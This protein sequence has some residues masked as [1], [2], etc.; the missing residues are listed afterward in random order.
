MKFRWFLICALVFGQTVLATASG[1]RRWTRVSS[2]NFTVVGDASESEIRGAAV[3]F[4]LFRQTLQELFSDR[5]LSNVPTTVFVFKSGAELNS[6]AANAAD[7]QTDNSAIGF[8]RAGEAANYIALTVEGDSQTEFQSVFH[9]YA[10]LLL[11]KSFG[12]AALPPWTSEGLAEY[13]ETLTGDE[14][15]IRLGA[16]AEEN[17]RFL[18]EQNFVPLERLLALDYYTLRTQGNHGKSIFYAESWALIHYLQEANRGAR[19]G[20]L[21]TFLNLL[22]T[23][24]EAKAAFAEAFQTDLPTLEKELREYARQ[25]SFPNRNV[26]LK[27]N[28]DFAAAMPSA[29]LTESESLTYQSEL[30]ISLDRLDEAANLLRRAV[31]LDARSTGAL[32]ALGETLARQNKFDEA[33]AAF[34][35]AVSLD[36]R[37]YLSLFR[38]A[39]A[40]RRETL[41]DEKF[42]RPISDEKTAQITDLL[43]RSI[44]LNPN[45]AAS[46]RLM[47]LVNL[48]NN[49][50]LKDA[51]TLLGKARTLEPG[52]EQ[53]LLDLGRVYFRLEKFDEARALARQVFA[54]AAETA[55]RA[56]AQILLGNIA[57]LEEQL[58]QIR[59]RN[60]RGNAD[61]QPKM[62]LS[63]EELI[64]QSLNE[65]LRK[66]RS[67][68]KRAVGYLSDINCDGKKVNFTVRLA[69][70]NANKLLR[71]SA[72]DFLSVRFMAFTAQASGKP[73]GCGARTPEDFVVVSYR[74]LPA[75]QNK[76]DGEIV[77][78]EFVPKTFQLRF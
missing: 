52:D 44:A 54:S 11:E 25:R 58:R 63:A 50:D 17:L 28:S 53:I 78:V 75:P 5:K 73:V 71:L 40:L 46:Y 12:R 61:N 6:F 62:E 49:V 34:E 26:L 66:P 23:G 43:T 1:E 27:N 64:N 13:Y 70:Q 4:E 65:A 2:P 10:D 47:A 7:N 32:A 31:A 72:D 60:A 18:R 74:P 37:N 33:R 9:D 21:K 55:T 39:D 51:V 8:L 38:Y 42:V 14:Q 16:T 76:F 59:E 41:P 48:A 36:A 3:R 69:E 56:N 30:L 57:S 19:R 68:E 20:E 67:G 45:F 15:N 24:R 29:V 22:T 77:A 35:K